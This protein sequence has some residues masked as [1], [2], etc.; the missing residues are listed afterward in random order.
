MLAF[1][2]FLFHW[3]DVYE[4]DLVE[5]R[6]TR[7]KRR[8]FVFFHVT[9]AAVIAYIALVA[10]KELSAGRFV[11]PLGLGI[12]FLRFFFFDLDIDAWYTSFLHHFGRLVFELLK[13]LDLSFLL[14]LRLIFNFRFFC[15][16]REEP[17]SFA[18][19]RIN[20]LER[21]LRCFFFFIG[22][23]IRLVL[24]F[25]FQGSFFFWIFLVFSNIMLFFFK[26]LKFFF[27]FAGFFVLLLLALPS[28]WTFIVDISVF[29][30]FKYL[31]L[32]AIRMQSEFFEFFL[33]D[34]D[35][36]FELLPAPD[37]IQHFLKTVNYW[38]KVV[39]RHVFMIS[40]SMR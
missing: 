40:D 3:Y 22:F 11:L 34:K 29:F 2:K 26:L 8:V 35:F 28:V 39:I 36:F 13:K 17:I 4:L 20:K 21:P 7:V 30:R 14:D 32:V 24:D 6:G 15:L 9:V 16:E 10:Y 38:H 19:K 31:W 1:K 25:M 18:D 33:N 5:F 12:F 27:V 23:M 37:T